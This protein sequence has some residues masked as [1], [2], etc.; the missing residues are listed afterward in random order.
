M[1]NQDGS[2]VVRSL[3]KENDRKEKEPAPDWN[4]RCSKL[5]GRSPQRIIQVLLPMAL[6]ALVLAAIIHPPAWHAEDLS[7][8]LGIVLSSGLI[9]AVIWRLWYRQLELRMGGAGPKDLVFIAV[10][11]ILSALITKGHLL[12]SS[13]L[14][15]GVEGLG[16]LPLAFGT[17]LL[18]G[19]LLCA[20]F[21]GP[22]AGMVLA[23]FTG[24]LASLFWTESSLLMI[25]FLV[26][27][28]VAANT[29]RKE[30]TRA[31]LLKAGTWAALAGAAMIFFASLLQGWAFSWN[32]AAGM[33]AAA[34][35]AI[36]S[37][38]L[39]AGLAPICETLF[40]YTTDVRLLEQASLD[41]PAL[42][43]LM[44]KAPG[45]YHH[46]LIVGSMVEAAAREIRANHLLARVAALYHDIGKTKKPAYFV[47]NQM[48]GIN[49][50][51]KLAPSMSALIL[52]S[53]VKEGKELAKKYR[54][55]KP[56]VDI[57]VQHHG[58]RVIH[59][60]YHKAKANRLAAG[61]GEPDMQAFRYP[62]PKPQ[63]REAGLVMLADTVEAAA[64]ALDNPAPARIQGLVSTQIN[65][66]FV[67]GQLD[68]CELTL[69]DLHK[70]AKVF[71]TILT[72]IFHQ[73]VEYPGQNDYRAKKRNAD[74]DR[75]PAADEGIRSESPRKEDSPGLKRLGLK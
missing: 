6:V 38:I 13:S 41:H 46:S 66:I 74:T 37:G 47:E 9:M 2:R 40:G 23:I 32:M 5:L 17:P 50:H 25:Y 22:Q 56:I 67:E 75:Q 54:L 72:G 70:I 69:K 27:G 59:Y 11:I 65:K 52:I 45:T 33:V 29:I 55:G 39:A 24:Y 53:H 19:V 64:R 71:T 34:L 4:S 51:E 42:G 30:H 12:F 1:A 57:M 62:G 15:Q 49:R 18:T 44:I 8:V 3:R 7:R 68:E 20:L 14:A 58:T 26:C 10:L 60:F 48:G 28:V 16:R 63:T 61:R 43:E 73:R 36:A 35:G 21:L 31:A